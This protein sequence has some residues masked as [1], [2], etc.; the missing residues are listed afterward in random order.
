MGFKLFKW[1]TVGVVLLAL[2][3]VLKVFWWVN[4]DPYVTLA[5]HLEGL[6]RVNMVGFTISYS[7]FRNTLLRTEMHM[8]EDRACKCVSTVTD[9]TP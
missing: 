3:V 7:Y 1:F 2:E 5:F 8:V 6:I 4:G 9:V